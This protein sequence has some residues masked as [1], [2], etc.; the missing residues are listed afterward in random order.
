MLLAAGP[1]ALWGAWALWVSLPGAHWMTAAFGCAALLTAAGLLRL[2]RWAKPLAYF[3]AAALALVWIYTVWQIARHG[4]PYPDRLGTVLSLI[5]GAL[6]L[7]LCAGG[8]WIVHT[9]YRRH[10][11]ES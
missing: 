7:I 4:W 9:Q 5:P 3:F 11:N 2:R 8:A 6:L 10:A 1:L